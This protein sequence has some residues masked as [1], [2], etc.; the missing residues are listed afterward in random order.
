[1]IWLVVGQALNYLGIT[2]GKLLEYTGWK[3]DSL[4]APNGNS[5]TY[6]TKIE[7]LLVNQSFTYNGYPAR[8]IYTARYYQ[9]SSTIFQ[10]TVYEVSDTL[11]RLYIIGKTVSGQPY[12][13]D[14]KGLVTPFTINNFWRLGLSGPYIGDFDNDNSSQF[15][16]TLWWNTDTAKVVSQENV[17]V[18]AGTFSAYKIFVRTKGRIWSSNIK[19]SAGNYG[20]DPYSDSLIRDYYLWWT[21][22]LGYVKDSLHAYVQF[23]GPFNS[24]IITKSWE[25]AELQFQT[26]TIAE[27]ES[28]ILY[29]RDYIS[30]DKNVKIY[31]IYGRIVFSGKG[32]VRLNRG[33]YVVKSEG[34][35][36]KL[37]VK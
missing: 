28:D 1:M 34:Y 17:T 9:S 29:S 8:G 24:R 13:V 5:G 10:D 27:R 14:I 32:K 31:D 3:R 11:R 37:I 16:D 33:I 25:K 15:V 7:T 36:R 26:T 6:S 12:K 22:G 23:N 21:P 4:L 2:N 20:F 18:P 19:Q 35:V 30:F